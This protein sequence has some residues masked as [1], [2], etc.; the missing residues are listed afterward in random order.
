MWASKNRQNQLLEGN[1]RRTEVITYYV[2]AD[3]AEGV[4]AA[5]IKMSAVHT[6]ENFDIIEA[7]SLGGEKGEG[8][9]ITNDQDNLHDCKYDIYLESSVQFP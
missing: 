8:V 7:I 3:G 2:G 5:H 6:Q 9:R 1:D 4:G